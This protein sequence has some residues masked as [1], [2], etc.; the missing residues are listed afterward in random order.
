MMEGLAW[1]Y[2]ILY[3][4]IGDVFKFMDPIQN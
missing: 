1:K 2:L 3:R 4:S